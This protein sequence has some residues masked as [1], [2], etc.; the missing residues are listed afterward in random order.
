MKLIDFTAYD[1]EI[2]SQIVAINA[3]LD[4]LE[5]R[6]P[7]IEVVADLWPEGEFDY[8]LSFGTIESEVDSLA[9]EAKFRGPDLKL[10]ILPQY[11]DP[12]SAFHRRA[13]AP[14][15]PATLEERAA[16]LVADLFDLTINDRS[17]GLYRPF[18]VV[19]CDRLGDDGVRMQ[20]ASRSVLEAYKVPHIWFRYRPGIVTGA[21]QD[22][23]PP[24]PV[25][26]LL[27][28]RTTDYDG[29]EVFVLVYGSIEALAP[30]CTDIEEAVAVAGEASAPGLGGGT[31]DGLRIVLEHRYPGRHLLPPPVLP[32]PVGVNQSPAPS[33]ELR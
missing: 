11:H 17:R 29:Y 14:C 9:L 8:W 26:V 32:P 31:G 21:A 12:C 27:R 2:Q 7:G 13:K 4:Q 6:L 22:R 10:D 24:D 15:D 20:V 16:G 23:K 1:E 19:D 30:Y 33:A 25:A 28:R 5:R 18:D 3:E